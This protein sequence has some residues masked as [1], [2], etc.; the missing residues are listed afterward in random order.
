[1]AELAMIVGSRRTLPVGSRVM[2]RFE[3]EE[4]EWHE[5]MITGC[6]EP[7]VY[8]I[9]T[10]DEDHY[11]EKETEW[12][13]CLPIG[14]RG[15]LPARVRSSGYYI[16][17]FTN[18]YSR[19]QLEKIMDE[20]KVVVEHYK[21]LL[22]AGAVPL[23]RRLRGKQP[24]LPIDDGAAASSS[25]AKDHRS[26][27]LAEPLDDLPIGTEVKDGRLLCH[28]G[29]HGLM[30]LRSAVVRVEK[31]AP[32][33]V[34][35]WAEART[36]QL[37]AALGLKDEAPAGGSETPRA[38]GGAES[39]LEDARTLSVKYD[40][41]GERGRAFNDGV[42]SMDPQVYEDWPLEP[43]RT[44]LY[45]VQQIAKLGYGPTARHEKWKGDNKLGLDDAG[46]TE[47]EIGSEILE[48]ATTY[49]QLDL[50]NCVCFE[51]L[52]RRLQF[53]EEGYRQKLESKRLEKASDV[54]AS[55]AEHF[56]G[57]P[58]MAGGAI[59]SPD[60]LRHAATRAAQD[61]EILK[62]QR[63]AAEVRGLLKGPKK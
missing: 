36:E 37:K 32:Q 44:C 50:S 11:V 24:A 51:R 20:G 41:R 17:R 58:R 2:V 40:A 47:H 4:P 53:I 21:K 38:G 57:R 3:E 42:N 23:R 49:D 18:P 61:N 62:Q 31:M 8:S 7:G 63:K 59:I 15:G 19:R 54:T 6:V 43:P 12:L 46:V 27:Y 5:R 45:Y 1:M 26:W 9:L 22:A 60:L 10:P 39:L 14:V 48:L 55:M 35:S 28:H 56:G 13:E 25:Q 33:H 34:F 16:H 29:D 52:V 30:S